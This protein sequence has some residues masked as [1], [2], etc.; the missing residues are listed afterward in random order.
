MSAW[1]TERARVAS[2]TRSRN[3]DDPELIAARRRL[4][5]SRLALVIDKT[6]NTEPALSGP[7]IGELAAILLPGGGAK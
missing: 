7:Q 1:T 6:I 4:K 5:T 2:L 3:A